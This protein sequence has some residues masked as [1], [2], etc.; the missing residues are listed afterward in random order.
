MYQRKLNKEVN[1]DGSVKTENMAVQRKSHH[2]SYRSFLLGIILFAILLFSS[3][4]LYWSFISNTPPHRFISEHQKSHLKAQP[5]YQAEP[6][7]KDG[8]IFYI[9]IKNPANF[10]VPNE[11]L[12]H[13]F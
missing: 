13:H 1:Q 12:H 2:S 3:L 7:N 11:L 8:E 6:D 10:N 5:V 4:A 9:S